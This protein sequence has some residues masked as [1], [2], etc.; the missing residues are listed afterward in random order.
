MI[1]SH[2]EQLTLK[3]IKY[4]GS[5]LQLWPSHL[6][7]ISIVNQ[8]TRAISSDVWDSTLNS[9]SWY[10]STLSGPRAILTQRPTLIGV[11]T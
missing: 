3:Q 9:R 7:I 11:L 8:L 4:K 6:D 2:W 1:K 10:S 5:L